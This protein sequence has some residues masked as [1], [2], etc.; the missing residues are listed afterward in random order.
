MEC[1]D[2]SSKHDKIAVAFDKILGHLLPEGSFFL[3]FEIVFGLGP[4]NTFSKV[5]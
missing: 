1:L 3:G 4:Q 2:I 5:L